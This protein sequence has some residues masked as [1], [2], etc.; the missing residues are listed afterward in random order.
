MVVVMVM[1]VVVVV[2]MVMVMVRIGWDLGLSG[3]VVGAG[4]GYSIIQTPCATARRR[5]RM[6]PT[7]RRIS[8]TPHLHARPSTISR[9][10]PHR[11]AG[12]FP[13]VTMAA[14]ALRTNEI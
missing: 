7:S 6:L 1:V 11:D 12:D 10:G 4:D 14:Q 13:A 8:P 3:S 2:V 5:C 9:F